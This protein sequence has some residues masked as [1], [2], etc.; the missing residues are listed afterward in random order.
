MQIPSDQGSSKNNVHGLG[1]NENKSSESKVNRG[2]KHEQVTAVAQQNINNMTLSNAVE[3][4]KADFLKGDRIQNYTIIS[5]RNKVTICKNCVHALILRIFGGRIQ[6]TGKELA[7]YFTTLNKLDN[8]L[9]QNIK[10]MNHVEARN[11]L[12]EALD[13][14]FS[15]DDHNSKDNSRLCLEMKEKILQLYEKY[16]HK[17]ITCAMHGNESKLRYVLDGKMQALKAHL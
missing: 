13:V 5:L 17:S 7:N 16:S 10:V 4:V 9:E 12:N 11:T 15:I 3:K 6:K 8:L 2:G 14:Y 1:S